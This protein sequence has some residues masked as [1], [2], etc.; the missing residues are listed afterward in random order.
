ML[1]LGAEADQMPR[2]VPRPTGIPASPERVY[3]LASEG[4]FV[5]AVAWD[6]DQSPEAILDFYRDALEGDGYDFRASHRLRDEQVSQQ[7]LWARNED[8]GRVVFVVTHRDQGDTKVLL[9]Y[10]EAR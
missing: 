9:G 10:G 5:G 1:A 6:S 8:R 7:S 3:S 4:E 2:W